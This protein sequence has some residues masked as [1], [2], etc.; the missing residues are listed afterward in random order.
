[1]ENTLKNKAKFFAQYWW[2][3]VLRYHNAGVPTTVDENILVLERQNLK[4]AWLELKSL[5]SISDEDAIAVASIILGKEVTPL[6]L[7][8]WDWQYR[9]IVNREKSIQD[10]NTEIEMFVSITYDTSEIKFTWDY[11]NS[12]GSGQQDRHCPNAVSAYD[13]LRSKSYALPWMG[14][15]VEKQEEYG[16]IKIKQ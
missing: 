10:E 13:Y 7:I 6:D 5:S 12:K 8:R 16:W 14:L 4:H 11:N 2:Q 15:S 9:V 3:E 1:M